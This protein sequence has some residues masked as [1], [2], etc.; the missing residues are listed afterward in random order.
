MVSTSRVTSI[1][2]GRTILFMAL[3]Y[4]SL[5]AQSGATLGVEGGSTAGEEGKEV[6]LTGL[7]NCQAC[8]E[9]KPS[10]SGAKCSPFGH[11]CV[12]TVETAVDTEG[13]EI[14][15]LKKKGLNYKL[16]QQGLPLFKN[17]EYRGARLEIK[18]KWFKEKGAVAVSS[19][20]RLEKQ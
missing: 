9:A 2:L 3:F 13:K 10:E 6:T 7:N 1:H 14:E 20:K 11:T 19:F 17:E 16:N 8:G 4:L 12:F 18:G 15:E 5:C